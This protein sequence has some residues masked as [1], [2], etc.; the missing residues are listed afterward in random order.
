MKALYSK[1][2]GPV[3]DTELLE[4]PVYS[5]M[6]ILPNCHLVEIIITKQLQISSYYTLA[7]V[8]LRL[9]RQSGIQ[10]WSGKDLQENDQH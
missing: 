5:L 1:V 3:R 2:M 8:L 6:L 9:S 10:D 7:I 4:H